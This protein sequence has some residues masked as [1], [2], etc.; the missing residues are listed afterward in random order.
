MNDIYGTD[1][2]KNVAP[3]CI[4]TGT[5]LNG[6]GYAITSAAEDK[7]IATL[8]TMID[9][10]YSEDGARLASL[11]LTPEEMRRRHILLQ[12]QRYPRWN[13]HHGR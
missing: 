3:D 2:C 5:A 9:Y 7:D 4:M 13:L 1:A 10:L 6:T 8:L 12:R 11:G